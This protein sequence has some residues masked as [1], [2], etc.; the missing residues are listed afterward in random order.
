MSTQPTPLTPPPP[1]SAPSG[2][3]LPLPTS[4]PL[5][6]RPVRLALALAYPHTRCT[7]TCSEQF[8]FSNRATYRCPGYARWHYT[9]P[10]AIVVACGVAPSWWA[11][12]EGQAAA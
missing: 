3:R 5:D 4:E 9:D 11:K 7:P 12:G 6:P 10:T 2:A 8:Q 1:P